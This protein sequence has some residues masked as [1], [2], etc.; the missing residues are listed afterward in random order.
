[1]TDKLPITTPDS[2]TKLPLPEKRFCSLTLFSREYRKK[3]LP[4]QRDNLLAARLHG[5]FSSGDIY[6]SCQEINKVR[7]AVRKTAARRYNSQPVRNQRCAYSAL[8][9]GV[10][11]FLKRRIR[12]I[13]SAKVVEGDHLFI[14]TD[15]VEH[16]VDCTKHHGW[17]TEVVFNFCG[18]FVVV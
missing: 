17:A 16:F 8:P 9:A 14:Y 3:T 4:L 2:L 6:K 18:I 13:C 1:M 11:V 15:V 5:I 10:L 12:N 7:R